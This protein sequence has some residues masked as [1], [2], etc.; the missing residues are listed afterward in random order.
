[1]LLRRQERRKAKEVYA[2]HRSA[3]SAEHTVRNEMK[4]GYVYLMANRRHGKTYLGV[5]S[6]L[7]QRAYQHKNGHFEGYSKDNKCIYLVWYEHHEDLQD[8]RRRE[9]QMKKWKRD[10]KHKL[11]DQDNPDWLDLY[12]TLAK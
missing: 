4:A 8:A 1:V 3:S 5:T 2:F 12:D 10:W 6:N 11:I 9:A 7:P